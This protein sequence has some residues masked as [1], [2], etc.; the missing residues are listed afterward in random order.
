[1]KL[2]KVLSFVLAIAIFGIACNKTPL[3]PESKASSAQQATVLSEGFETGVKTAY[4][5]AD[6]TLGTGIW[7]LNEALIGNST[8]DRKVGIA[9]ARVRNSGMLTMKF[10]VTSGIGTVIIQHGRYG[11]DASSTWQLW[12]STDGGINYLQA[13]TTISTTVTTLS[14]A[15]FTL[16]ITGSARLQI[17][18]TDGTTSRVNFDAITITDYSGTNPLPSLSSIAPSSA[19]AGAAA[20]ALTVTGTNFINGSSILWNGTPLTTTFV[21]TTQLT[22]SVAS[23]LLT[24][25]GTATVA[26]STPAPGGGVTS[27]FT[28]TINAVQVSTAKKF[29]FDASHAET[30]GNADWVIDQDNS[31]PQRIPT[32]S[33]T[34][35]TATTAESYWTGGI[36]AWGIA[37]VKKGHLVETLPSTGTITYGSTTNAQDLSKYDVFVVDEPNKRF[38]TA[39]KTAMLQFVQNGGGL[40][41]VGNHTVSDRDNDGWDS[42]AIWNDMF[43]TNSIQTNPFGVTFTLN[44]ISEVTSNKSTAS[45]TIL[46]GSEGSVAQLQFNS[47]STMSISTAANPNVRGLIWRST[48]TQSTSNIMAASSTFG[49]GRVFLIGDS[50]PTDDG[51]GAP[52]NTLFNG[53]GVYSHTRLMMNASLWLAKIQ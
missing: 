14:T 19:T 18:K 35:I 25:A 6:I 39:E 34:G 46:N 22:A 47:G 41:V 20:L 12:Y 48:S 7:N 51:T 36:S 45:S 15:T 24:T 33:Y 4:T 11:T 50:S 13:G 44:N 17:R 27:N 16:N 52:N 21:S 42:P 23:T 43:S 5:A 49:A 2:I 26:V 9:S 30:A 38:T 32:P 37:L 53:W 29:L 10:N 3:Q 8:S 28:I 40:F 1:M 31:T